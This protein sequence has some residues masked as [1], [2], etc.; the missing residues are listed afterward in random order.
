[1]NQSLILRSSLNR[2]LSYEEMDGNLEYLQSIRS[3]TGP[4]GPTG[5]SGVRSLGTRAGFTGGAT[6]YSWSHT[7]PFLVID[8]ATVID[9]LT[10]TLPASAS[11]QPR[12]LY[13][14][15]FGGQITSSTVVSNLTLKGNGIDTI[16]ATT[17]PTQMDAGDSLS[18]AWDDVSSK[19]RLF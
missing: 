12:D 8:P 3:G 7:T 4:S 5:P 16:L 9:D 19:W 10:V 17:L 2:P 14:L 13:Y 1:M 11:V 15:S 6:G 18:L